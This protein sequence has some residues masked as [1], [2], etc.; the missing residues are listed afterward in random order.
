MKGLRQAL[1]SIVVMAVVLAIWWA[2]VVVTESA[3]FPTPWQ[4]VTGTME[5]E[6]PTV[7]SHSEAV[8]AGTGGAGAHV[9]RCAR[10]AHALADTGWP[11]RRV[12]AGKAGCSATDT[13]A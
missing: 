2:A 10:D 3:I 1:P 8:G 4:V 11:L 6:I 5:L 13:A 7:I 9:R 12:C